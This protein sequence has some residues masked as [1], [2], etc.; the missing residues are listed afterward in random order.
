MARPCDFAFNEQTGADN[1]FQHRLQLPAAEVTALALA[2][3][4]A[5][6]QRLR[7]HG[8]EVLVLEKARTATR[9]RTRCFP[10]TGSA[11]AWMAACTFI[12]CIP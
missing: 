2:E 11:P 8:V 12:L 10:I 6:A 4:D 9:R 3:F 7:N 1:V 5:M